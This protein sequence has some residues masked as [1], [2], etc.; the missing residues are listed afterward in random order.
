MGIGMTHLV[1]LASLHLMIF[2]PGGYGLGTG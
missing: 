1:L 2:R